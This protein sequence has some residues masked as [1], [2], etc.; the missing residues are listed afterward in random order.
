MVVFLADLQNSYYRYLRNSVPLGM[1]FVAAY[2][3]K[4]FGKE[5]EIHQFRKFEEI[6]EALKTTTPHIAAFGSY[7]WNTLLTRKTA[8]YLR[9]RFPDLVIVVGGPDVSHLVDLTARDLR[10]NPHID[11]CIPEEGEEPMRNL[12]EAYLGN[13]RRSALREIGVSGCLSLD[14]R[15]A[16][17]AG[18]GG[19][20]AAGQ[21]LMLAPS[22][23]LAGLTGTVGSRITDINVIPSPYL[24]G[25]MDRFL[26][27]PDYLP[28]I[29]T[30]RGC[31]YQCTFCVSGKDTWNK[32]KA[33]EL[34]R[35]KAEI[36]YV[37][38][39]AANPYMRFADENFGILRRDVEIAEYLVETRRQVGFP[40]AVSI[41]TDK[42][43]TDRVKQIN[44]ILKDLLPFNISFQT[45]TDDVLKN[46]KRINLKD[47]VIRGTV[48]FAR[49]NDLMLVTELIFALPGETK[50]SFLESID[51][52]MDY[53][54]ESVAI[55]QLRILKGSEMDEPAD[56]AKH[57]VR[58]M[59][60]VSEN[61]YT[62]HSELENIEID[63][64]VV[65]NR[66]LSEDEYFQM[67]RFIF[68]FYF[69]HYRGYLKELLFFFE[70]HDIRASAVLMHVLA[71]PDRC[72]LLFE[73]AEKFQSAL[74]RLLRE[75]P[76]QAVEAVRGTARDPESIAGM[77]ALS[78][79]LI[80]ELLMHDKL[81]QAF[82]EVAA[83]G[84]TLLEKR[85]GGLPDGFEEQ[86]DVLR[87]LITEAFIPL[88]RRVPEEIVIETPFDMLKWAA[89]NYDRPPSAYRA[90]KPFQVGL[91]IR[92]I[93]NYDDLWRN[94]K[95]TDS[96]K[97]RKNFAAINS[98]N[99]RRILVKPAVAVQA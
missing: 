76:E 93:R 34:D 69:A 97:Y 57:E 22:P 85:C 13:P 98:S 56:R 89:S 95:E 78:D 35:V 43:P 52:L 40:T 29:Q 37:A 6:C 94:D 84:R 87:V 63:E 90:D 70:S 9:S 5:I 39:R 25:L 59:F 64:W 42:H 16:S 92:N 60:A 75:T 33:F 4:E 14:E 65:A 15:L 55:N 86:I 67:N 21:P 31:P 82:D 74:K 81:G 18:R 46:I 96:D 62:Q 12:V 7:S 48:Q 71:H 10:A 26:D 3:Q 41:Y 30:A 88:H 72:P 28:I 19:Q 17:Y 80:I 58:T 11:F 23:D 83:V 2:L 49:E 99:R 77:S 45:L 79:N 44:L 47:Q 20:L 53:R 66:T 50:E 8:A 24:S 32:V 91:R 73:R 27:D 38:A 1:G 54:F 51:R 61:G 36:D 68:L